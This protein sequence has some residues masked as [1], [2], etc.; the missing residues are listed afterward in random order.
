MNVSLPCFTQ[1][2]FTTTCN[3]LGLNYP[4][5]TLQR[6]W[7]EKK[8]IKIMAVSAAVGIKTCWKAQLMTNTNRMSICDLRGHIH[9]QQHKFSSQLQFNHSSKRWYH[10]ST[11]FPAQTFDA[12]QTAVRKLLHWDAHWSSGT[13][14]TPPPATSRLCLIKQCFKLCCGTTQGLWDWGKML[15]WGRISTRLIRSRRT[16]TVTVK[17]TVK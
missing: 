4:P 5:Y 14:I 7:E 10:F 3:L 16:L 11:S 12:F 1:I 2:S 17:P 15:P 8:C 6:W 13:A 9:P